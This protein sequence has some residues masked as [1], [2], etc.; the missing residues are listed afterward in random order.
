MCGTEIYTSFWFGRWHDLVGKGCLFKGPPLEIF[1]VAAAGHAPLVALL[2]C[3]FRLVAFQPFCLASDAACSYPTSASFNTRRAYH[4]YDKPTGTVADVPLRLLDCLGLM[5]PV[6]FFAGAAGL[7]EAGGL[8]FFLGGGGSGAGAG[9]ARNA[10][11]DG[12]VIVSI[13]T[14][15][16]RETSTAPGAVLAGARSLWCGE[17]RVVVEVALKVLTA[18]NRCPQDKRGAEGLARTPM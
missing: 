18:R 8:G 2:A 9:E 11:G 14:A 17:G 6:F 16:C 1:L 4:G 10:V 7:L 5:M 15:S 12:I 3:R 13:V